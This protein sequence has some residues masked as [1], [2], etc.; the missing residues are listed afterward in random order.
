[1]GLRKNVFF[2]ALIIILAIALPVLIFSE[3]N[4][5]AVIQYGLLSPTYAVPNNALQVSVYLQNVGSADA[6]P[7][8]TLQ[9][10][11]ATI[12]EV[13]IPS[14][15][16]NKLSSFYHFNNETATIDNITASAG[17]SSDLWAI[18]YVIPNNN[19]SAFSVYS[20]VKIPFDFLHI[21][22]E[23]SPTL[24]NKISYN[25]SPSHFFNKSYPN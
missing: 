7:I 22:N 21:R 10:V 25:L 3:Y 12:Q 18:V 11:N 19:T 8:F 23:V 20:S 13:S 5:Y 4:Y 16:D 6:V 9:V 2:R 1:M 24:T 14:I 15:A 17:N